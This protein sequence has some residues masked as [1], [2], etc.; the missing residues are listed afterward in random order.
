MA[1]LSSSIALMPV[2]RTNNNTVVLGNF[3]Q[4]MMMKASLVLSTFAGVLAVAR[5]GNPFSS[6]VVALTA[7]NWRQEVEE[8]PLAVF[9]NICRQG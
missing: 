7:K 9:I 6:N 8:S 1:L 5:A 2:R 3:V 4:P